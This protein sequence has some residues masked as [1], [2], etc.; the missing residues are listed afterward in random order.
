MYCSATCCLR[1]LAADAPRD[2]PT[3]SARVI[4]PI[5]LVKA[6]GVTPAARLKTSPS[7]S[8]SPQIQDYPVRPMVMNKS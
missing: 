4:S 2:V 3:P 6:Q 7:L 1:Q 5:Q 8:L